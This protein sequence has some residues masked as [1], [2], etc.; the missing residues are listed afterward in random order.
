MKIDESIAGFARN[1][2]SKLEYPPSLRSYGG[3]VE[4]RNKLGIELISKCGKMLLR[5]CIPLEFTTLVCL[6]L[7]HVRHAEAVNSD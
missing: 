6:N 2:N 1:Q 5:Q 7:K 4:V 3:Q